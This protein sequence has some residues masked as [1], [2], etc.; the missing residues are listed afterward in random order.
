MHRRGGS[1]LERLLGCAGD[2]LVLWVVFGRASGAHFGLSGGHFGAPGR[3]FWSLRRS[4]LSFRGCFLFFRIDSEL[5]IPFSAVLRDYFCSRTHFRDNENDFWAHRIDS[6][7]QLLRCLLL[8]PT[9]AL[10]LGQ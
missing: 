8:N 1:G 3:S 7:L 6:E 5:W 9:S 4:F 10:V 2:L